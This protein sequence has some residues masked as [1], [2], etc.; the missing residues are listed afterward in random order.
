[1]SA[2][3]NAKQRKIEDLR[4]IYWLPSTQTVLRSSFIR[5]EEQIHT[6]PVLFP[7][8]ALKPAETSLLLKSSAAGSPAFRYGGSEKSPYFVVIDFPAWSVLFVTPATQLAPFLMDSVTL[9]FY[10]VIRDIMNHTLE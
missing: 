10:N 2:S 7:L 9:P 5:Y 8:P 3:I 1:M 4:H 6:F